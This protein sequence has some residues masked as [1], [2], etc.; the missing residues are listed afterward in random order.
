MNQNKKFV[1]HFRLRCRENA[2]G[3]HQ[4]DS[5][6][7]GGRTLQRREAGPAP[8]GF[9]LREEGLTHTT[10]MVNPWPKVFC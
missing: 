6:I 9:F 1:N 7:S 2:Y 5:P 8:G 3:N 4:L 10:A